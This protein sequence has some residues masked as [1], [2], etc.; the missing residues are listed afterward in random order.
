MSTLYDV[1]V[2]GGGPSG[3]LAARTLAAAG[4][5]VSLVEKS[6]KRIKPCGGATPSK[7]FEEFNLSRKEIVRKIKTLSTVSPRGNRFDITLKNGYIAMVQ[8]E[9]FDH[10]IRKQA[11]EAGADLREA[12]FIR[13]NDEHKKISITVNERGKMRDIFSDFLVAADGINSRTVQAA[14]LKSL[15]GICTI[16]EEIDIQGA[17]DFQ[18]LHTCELWFSSSHAHHFYSWVF[19]KKDHVDIGTGAVN[20]KLIKELLKNF[21][22]RRRI[23]GGGAQ[24]GHRLPLQWRDSLVKGN[25]LFVGDAAGLVMPLIYEGIYYALKSGKMAAEAIINGSPKLYEKQWNKK[26]RRQFKFMK[27]LKKY[28]FKNDGTIDHIFRLHESNEVQD[29][30]MKLWL[31][32][33]VSLSTFFSYLNVFKRLLH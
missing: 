20:G 8:R 32:K 27:G 1:V 5:K 30:S 28:F 3:A 15:P 25:I 26:F 23:H 12:E 21:K 6:F 7:T 4:V 14:G 31:E 10:A 2:V 19:P 24:R 33:D 29:I 9:T 18:N 17:E 11:E 22:I 13:I 16:Q